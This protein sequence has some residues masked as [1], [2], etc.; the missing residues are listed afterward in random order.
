MITPL[1]G[2]I[3][4]DGLTF[5]LIFPPDQDAA[6]GQSKHVV[7]KGESFDVLSEHAG[8][9]VPVIDLRTSLIPLPYDGVKEEFDTPSFLF[10]AARPP[11]DAFCATAQATGAVVWPLSKENFRE[12]ASS[13]MSPGVTPAMIGEAERARTCLGLR[14]RRAVDP[15]VAV[16][17]ELLSSGMLFG[18]KALPTQAYLDGYLKKARMNAE[19]AK[20]S[21]ERLSDLPGKEEPVHRAQQAEADALAV[22]LQRIPH[23]RFEA[24]LCAAIA[25]RIEPANSGHAAALPAEVDP[26]WEHFTSAIGA[27]IALGPVSADQL[28]TTALRLRTLA[29]FAFQEH[30]EIAYGVPGYDFK[31]WAQ[32][33]NIPAALR[34]REKH[35]REWLE[36]EPPRADALQLPESGE[37]NFGEQA[38][39]IFKEPGIL[40]D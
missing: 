31:N 14:P 36:L 37:T 6:T 8:S 18:R 27:N 17:Q 24:A 33:A 15:G 4:E 7:K 26:T 30:V 23:Q 5:S 25:D 29:S 10:G 35:L 32:A 20:A 13:G 1:Y 21:V 34:T 22:L 9:N 38:R 2:M 11:L 19:A 16:R 3:S 12:L 39:A 40:G 28:R